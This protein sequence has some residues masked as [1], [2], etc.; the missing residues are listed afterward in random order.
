M[1]SRILWYRLGGVLTAALL[2]TAAGSVVEA[3]SDQRCF[4]ETGY[5]IEGRIRAFWEQNGGL[6]VFGLPITP[7]QY[8]TI[9]GQTLQVQ[10]FERNRLE[11]HP[12]HA[13]P[14]DVL[15]GRLGADRLQQQARDPFTFATS[16]PQDGC[17]YFG[18]TRHN[19]CGDVLRAW[20][21]SGIDVDGVAGINEGESLA[22]WGLPL[23]DLQVETLSDGKQYQVQWFERGR[24]ELH[25]EYAPPANVLLG[26]LGSEV[27]AGTSA[28]SPPSTTP[29]AAPPAQ[30]TP[31]PTPQPTAAPRQE[32]DPSYPDVCI[33][34][35]P[36]DLDCGDIPYK[37]FRV[38]GRDPHRFDGDHDGIGCER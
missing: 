3:Q 15:L 20:R 16:T 36:P 19:V 14:Y 24:F 26:L 30:P 27:R 29:P 4:P 23:S 38:I 28:V 32:C 10:W 35:P 11:L 12:E 37:R 33:P 6:T 17:R 2:L 13:A 1:A 21:A 5:C 18:E 34:S 25:P 9:Q 31:L 22:L 8:E 7:Q